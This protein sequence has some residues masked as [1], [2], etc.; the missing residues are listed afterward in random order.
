MKYI[1]GVLAVVA[2]AI[3]AIILLVRSPSS[4]N[5]GQKPGAKKIVKITDF[6]NS[7]V[8]QVEWKIQGRLVGEDQ[9]RAVRVTISQD[10]RLIEILDGYDETVERAQT[11]PNTNSAYD[12]FLHAL[13]LAGF[14]RD[15]KVAITD[16]RGVCPLG[17]TFIYDLYDG[18]DHPVHLWSVS[19]S[20]A[21][22]NFAGNA[23]LIR[24]LFQ[25]QISDYNTQTKNVQ[26]F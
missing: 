5:N 9:R 10:R 1:L 14:G 12:A 25:N 4:T 3:I 13:E 17:N 11:Y 24:Q 8:S 22:G 18:N 15:R 21:F 26:L 19:C 16:E 20:T 23:T 6:A 7:N 2:I